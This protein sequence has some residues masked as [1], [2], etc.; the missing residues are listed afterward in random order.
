MLNFLGGL[1]GAAGSWLGG[2]E[3]RDDVLD[4]QREANAFLRDGQRRFEGTPIVQTYMP[5]GA[6]AFQTRQALLGLGGDPQA[7]R[8]AFDNYLNSTDFQFALETGRDAITGSRAARGLLDSGRTGAALTQFGSDLGRRY[9]S[10]YL[11]ELGRDSQLG[12]NAGQT[13]GNV[14][15]GQASQMAQIAQ[16]T[17]AANAEITGNMWSG[18]GAGA[19]QMLGSQ[20]SQRFGNVLGNRFFG[21]GG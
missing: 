14:L 11:G 20:T 9:M 19:G 18:I 16:N 5:G 21:G 1:V 6:Q 8:Q 7:A 4:A 3:Q 10:N 17:G 13:Y 2:R 12:F 15:T